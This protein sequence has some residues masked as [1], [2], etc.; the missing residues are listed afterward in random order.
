MFIEPYGLI[1]N[2]DEAI[3]LLDAG[4][5]Y[6]ILPNFQADISGGIGI[7]ELAI[8]NFISLGFSY[9]IP[10]PREKR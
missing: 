4:V 2:R 8:D 10:G 9:R 3:H 6:L 7:N 1:P 5:I